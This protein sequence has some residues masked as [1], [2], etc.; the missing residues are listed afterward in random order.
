MEAGVIK[1]RIKGSV[2]G[3]AVVDAL[4][5]P[6][7]FQPRGSF[8][9][10]TDFQHNANF[11]LVPG[12]WTDD[13][14]LTLCLAKAHIDSKGTFVAQSAIRNYINWYDHGYLSATDYCFDIGSATAKALTIWKQYFDQSPDVQRDDPL[15]HENGQ[16]AIDRV[17]K[18]ERC[19]GN[20]SLMRVSPIGLV[21]FRDMNKALEHAAASSDA[22][23]PYPTCAECCKI[24]TK[25]FVRTLNGASKEEL[26]AE[27]A[28]TI[29]QDKNVKKRLS[30]YTRIQDWQA[31]PERDI[32]S[33]GYVV[34]TLDAAL[35]SLF[36]T[37]TFESGALKVVSLGWDADTVG[38]VYGGLAGAFYG[39]EA[40]P[41]RWVE[42]LQKRDVVEEIASGLA[43]L[44]Q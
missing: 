38:A 3:V 39:L 32:D 15:G 5:A 12:T 43:T 25:L 24:Y 41:S 2:F 18:R 14:S 23:H 33:S 16:P 37:E 35:W 11:S 10:V 13:T 6:V 1:S 19:C 44:G 9:P 21:Y 42:G 8:D 17:L 26:A 28:S 22:T 29:F 34:S 27:V 40:I 30:R 4:G 7:E 20:G 36:T 31:T